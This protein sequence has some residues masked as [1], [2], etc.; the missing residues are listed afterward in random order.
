MRPHPRTPLLALG[1]CLLAACGSGDGSNPGS[2]GGAE[3][4]DS[5][6]APRRIFERSLVFANSSPNSRVMVPWVLESA[7]RPGGV[8]RLHRGWLLRDGEWEPFYR[9]EWSTGPMRA[10]WRVLPRGP[11]RILVGDGDRLDRVIYEGDGP[12]VQLTLDES[13]AEWTDSRGGSFHLLDGGLVLGDRRISGR[14]LDVSGGA[15]LAEP[16]LGDWLFLASSTGWSVVLGAPLEAGGESAFQG[17]ALS[18]DDDEMGPWSGVSIS[19]SEVRTFEPAR[20]PIPE[21]LS[22]ASEDG[23]LSGRLEV[24][25]LELETREGAGPVFPVD[26]FLGVTGEVQVGDRGSIEVHGVMRHRRR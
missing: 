7:T 21:V 15:R 3:A 19:W 23:D 9:E 17:W 16:P 14:V 4:A 11:F 2:G 6:A 22:I 26:G 1:V 20:R 10:P 8:D 25:S 5:A 12:S 18:P 13:L 24:T